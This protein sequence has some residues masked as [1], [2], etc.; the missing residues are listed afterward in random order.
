MTKLSE[1]GLSIVFGAMMMFFL[2][3]GCYKEAEPIIKYK[4]GETIYDT[5]YHNNTITINKPTP[6]YVESTHT[7]TV[8][9]DS[10]NYCDSIRYYSSSVDS[11]GL[12]I[13]VASKVNGLLLSQEIKYQIPQVNSSRID[14]ITITNNDKAKP[15]AVYGVYNTLDR[16]A[17]IG[18]AYLH[19]KS[20]FTGTYNMSNK[21][22]QIGYGFRF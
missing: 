13:N 4:K 14:T 20:F 16:T 8:Y 9:S 19:N 12:S 3:K 6:Y 21:A 10:I 11:S 17:A 1:I 22:I 18:G 2:M 5:I 7:D 15:F